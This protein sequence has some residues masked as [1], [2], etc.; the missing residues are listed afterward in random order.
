MNG[1]THRRRISHHGAG[2]QRALRDQLA[3]RT[4][5]E[6]LDDQRKLEADEH[7]ERRVEEEDQDLPDGVSL[8]PGGRGRQLGGEATHVDA[9]GHRGEDARDADRLSREIREVGGGQGD[10]DLDGRVVEPAPDRGDDRADA[11]ADRDAADRA[12][13]E[14]AACLEQAEAAGH[15]GGDRELVRDQRRAVVD[16]ALALDDRDDPVRDT[17][18]AP[19]GGRRDRVGGGD[20][21]AQDER[22]RPVESQG[23]VRHRRDADHRRQDEAD[24]QQGD[25]PDIPAKLAKRREERRRVQDRRQ[26]DEQD[27]VGFEGNL[28]RAGHERRAAAPP[29]ASRIGYGMR[30]NCAATSS[31]TITSQDER[32]APPRGASGEAT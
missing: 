14:L 19:D 29:T 17:E 28:G 30:R 22:G 9:D 26:E 2:D 3:E 31:A 18:L 13:H 25:R 21:R 12:D 1:K 15:D 10:R 6:A 8:D 11:D 27:E 4:V 7:E 23:E 24:R 32:S 5:V 20:D 16:E